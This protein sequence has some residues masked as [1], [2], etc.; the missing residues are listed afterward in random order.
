MSFYRYKIR[1][2]NQD[3]AV[4]EIGA[5]D[6]AQITDLVKQADDGSFD[7]FGKL[8]GIYLDRIYRYVFY[9]VEDQKTA[10]DLTEE[11]FLKVWWDIG[12]YRSNGN[13]LSF[14]AWLYRIAHN[15][16]IANIRT[17][18]RQVPLDLEASLNVADPNWGAEMLLT[19]EE[20]SEL[21]SCL[22][23]EQRQIIILKFIEGLDNSEIAKVTG[24][25]QEAIRIIQMSSLATL[26]RRLIKE[27]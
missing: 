8:Y 13:G 10:E 18:Q 1:G 11:V 15:H 12:S 7:A 6:E 16:I 17:R 22:F 23:P 4:V 3:Q 5:P 26:R 25:S 14:S 20:V 24:K 9:Q 21:V 19:Q 2:E 27:G